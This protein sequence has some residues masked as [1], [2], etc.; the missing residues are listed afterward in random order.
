MLVWIMEAIVLPVHGELKM[1]I[2]KDVLC[3]GI[4][5]W[6]VLWGG[7][8]KPKYILSF[9][10]EVCILNWRPSLPRPMLRRPSNDIR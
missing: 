8:K 9:V 1:F 2:L 6:H 7:K 5:V 3:D 10:P 4:T